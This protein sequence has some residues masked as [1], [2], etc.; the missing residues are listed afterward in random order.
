[1]SGQKPDLKRCH[2]DVKAFYNAL[3]SHNDSQPAPLTPDELAA[4]CLRAIST[5]AYT[6]VNGTASALDK[7]IPEST[8]NS[9]EVPRLRPTLVDLLETENKTSLDEGFLRHALESVRL[10]HWNPSLSGMIVEPEH[11]EGNNQL[12]VSDHF[13]SFCDCCTISVDADSFTISHCY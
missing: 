1:M 3:T 13:L 2:A 7:L 5:L 6:I 8:A 12:P 11:Q 4:D 10:S 9:R